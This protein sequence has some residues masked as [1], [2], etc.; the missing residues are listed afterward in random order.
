SLSEQQIYLDALTKY[1]TPDLNTMIFQLR[2]DI[3]FQPDVSGGRL[4]TSDDLKFTI[5]RAP[6]FFKTKGGLASPILFSWIDHTETPDNATVVI[7]QGRPNS[8]RVQMMA[9]T[10]PY[11]IVA[12]DVV[13]ANNGA[14]DNVPA[15]SGPYRL[16]KRDATGTTLQ[17]WSGYSKNPNP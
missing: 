6:V 2:Q 3:R 9:Q 11:G 15:G 13:E 12:R 5:D 7:K 1:E 4:M 10:N 8:G 17:R 14:V 16:T